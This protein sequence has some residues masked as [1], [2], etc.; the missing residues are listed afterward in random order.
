MPL[1]GT[2]VNMKESDFIEFQKT[3]I[4]P[5]RLIISAA[6]VDDHDKF[7]DMINNKLQ[8][9]YKEFLSRKFKPDQP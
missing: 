6:N 3:Y 1:K 4:T 5:E 9:E 7:V 8:K 2:N